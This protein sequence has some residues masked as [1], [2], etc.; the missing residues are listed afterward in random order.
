MYLVLNF[1][2]QF[3]GSLQREKKRKKRKKTK[4]RKKK[5]R[6]GRLPTVTEVVDR[7]T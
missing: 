6:S 7:S 3:W 5:S 2:S 4:R 1:L